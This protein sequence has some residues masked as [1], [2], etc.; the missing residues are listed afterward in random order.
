ME[1]FASAAP[2]LERVLASELTLLGVK[3]VKAVAGGAEFSGGWPEICRANLFSRTAGRILIRIAQFP[4][5]S[6]GELA[7]KA[8]KAP[9][10]EYFSGT[11]VEIEAVCRKSRLLHTAKVEK[12][13]AEAAAA[14]LPSTG[15]GAALYIRIYRDIVTLSVDASGE[16]LHRRGYRK[17]AGVAPLR[18]NVAAACLLKLGYEGSTPL[19][20][21]CCGSG[22]FAVEAALIARRIPPGFS[23]HF[24]F[25]EFPSLDSKVWKEEK[26]RAAAL[27][28]PKAPQPILGADVSREALTLAAS[29]AKAAGVG[30]D[31][32]LALADMAELSAPGETGLLVANPPY[33]RR[34]GEN[35]YPVLAEM[36]ETG[37]SGWDYGIL[38][39]RR[40]ANYHFSSGAPLVEFRSGGLPLALMS[41]REGEA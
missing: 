8:A 37:F 19:L 27:V 31:V 38:E 17:L 20:D 9:W 6:F 18:E 41:N 26:E 34:L 2:G 24:A 33:G 36:V 22:T 16:H 21:P 13:V 40:P 4:A 12:A 7:R 3:G 29:S 32:A 23:R 1:A 35:L 11:P 28:L 39:C 30:E 14:R 15:R 10:G 25:E 5:V